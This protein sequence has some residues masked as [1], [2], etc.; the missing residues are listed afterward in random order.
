MKSAYLM[1]NALRNP[2]PVSLRVVAL[3]LVSL[4]C[5]ST[6]IADGPAN[7][8]ERT[9]PGPN[10]GAVTPPGQTPPAGN[11]G[12]A[13]PLDRNGGEA[14]GN[15]AQA[16]APPEWVVP[17]ARFTQYGASVQGSKEVK[18]DQV[19]GAGG[20]SFVQY[21]IVAVTEI[22]VV[23]ESRIYMEPPPGS[24]G[25]APQLTNTTTM[26]VDHAT[27][28]GLWMLPADIT[29]TPD[30]TDPNAEAKVERGPYE[31]DGETY[32]A[33]FFITK[34]GNTTQR[35]VYD[36][37]TG[38]QLFQ[39]DLTEDAQNRSHAFSE[40]KGY[41]V[42][43][44]PWIG[45][46]F[47]PQMQGFTKLSYEGALI[48]IAPQMPG[49]ERMPD[50]RLELEIEIEFAIASPALIAAT[51]TFAMEMP[52]GPNQTNER[53]DMICPGQRLG[54]YIDP[55]VLSRLERGQVLDEDPAIGYRIVVTDVFEVQ[56]ITLVEITEQGRNN[57]YYNRGTYDASV[58]LQVASEWT[59]PMMSQRIEAQLE[60][61]E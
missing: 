46:E 44:L 12:G 42:A 50:T 59:Q 47:T 28:G 21:D 43:Q 49:L 15:N 11:P 2:W 10:G 17:G 41:R 32:E 6:A 27:G 60:R 55:A 26:L 38:I 25:G 34:V 53:R 5:A 31:I 54:L 37:R 36:R 24:G 16:A 30:T 35:R 51:M 20:T 57:S 18:P 19:S 4:C 7:P 33:I 8:L 58:G 3:L 39:S 23:I 1:K 48:A 61:V 22:G 52:Q 29:A 14:G 45:T 13:N 56:G 9:Q 40:Y